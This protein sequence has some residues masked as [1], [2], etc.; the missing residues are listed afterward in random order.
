[1]LHGLSIGLIAGWGE[2]EIARQ[3]R[4][5]SKNPCWTLDGG[6]RRTVFDVDLRLVDPHNRES[7]VAKF[8][9]RLKG[10]T[11]FATLQWIAK[12]RN[13]PVPSS[14]RFP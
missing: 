12:S 2:Y 8:R 3:D 7:L 10:P 11:K 14:W 1:M 6:K 9:S 13:L 4:Y 5:P